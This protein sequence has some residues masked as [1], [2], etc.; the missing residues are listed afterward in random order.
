MAHS[1]YSP[2]IALPRGR[3]APWLAETA[4]VALLLMVFIGL[5]PFAP[6]DPATLAIGESGFAGAGAAARRQGC[7]RYAP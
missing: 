1:G 3:F 7:S 2:A 6:R 5:M 4:F